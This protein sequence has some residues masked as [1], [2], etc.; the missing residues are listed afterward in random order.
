MIQE[1]CLEWL[2]TVGRNRKAHYAPLL[3]VDMVTPVNPQEFPALSSLL[4][5]FLTC[6]SC[7]E[8]YGSRDDLALS[9]VKDEKMDVVGEG[10]VIQDAETVVL[11]RL[12]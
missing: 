2:I 9:L 7:N 6:S 3:A 10:H 11:F 8:L 5:V 12:E 4:V 1:P